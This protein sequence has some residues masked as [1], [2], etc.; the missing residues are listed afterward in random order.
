MPTKRTLY[1]RLVEQLGKDFID[2]LPQLLDYTLREYANMLPKGI[3]RAVRY[4]IDILPGMYLEKWQK[5]FLVSFF[6]T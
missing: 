3:G 2:A 4:G 6:T 5:L 1:Q